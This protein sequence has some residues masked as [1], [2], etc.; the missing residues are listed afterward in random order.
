MSGTS[1]DGLDAA[2][3]RC[4]GRAIELINF[5]SAPMPADL[6]GEIL[7]LCRP[8]NDEIR[9][10]GAAE[11]RLATLFAERTLEVAGARRA[12]VRAIGSHG[13]TVR[14]HPDEPLPFTVQLGN[15]SLIAE[16]TGITVVADFRR[17]DMAAGGQAAPLAPA[18]HRALFATPDE[19]RAVL[20]LGGIANLTLL[21]VN[22]PVLGFDTGPGNALM[23]TWAERHLGEARDEGGRWAASGKPDENLLAALMADSYF[24]LPPPKSTGREKFHRE[25]LGAHLRGVG[26]N[27]QPADVQA[28]LVELTA[29]TVGEAL[30]RHGSETRRLLVSGGGI[31]N[32][33]LMARLGDALPGIEVESTAARGIDPDAV[34][35]V[36]FAWLAHETL[37]GRPGNIPEVTGARGLRILGGIYQA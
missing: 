2:L 37:H 12:E 24:S 21:P 8:G 3:V 17:R 25:W 22:G 35:A 10:A 32:A 26:G 9:R 18:F 31:H 11:Q 7:A 20:N 6:R 29:R 15:P 33:H 30:L 28:T 4:D 14:H 16:L 27:L 34:E 36:G 1:A 5:V 19:T 23:D 13:Q